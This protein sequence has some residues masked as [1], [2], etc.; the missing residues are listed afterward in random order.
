MQTPH[1]IRNGSPGVTLYAGTSAV[2]TQVV[3]Y[4]VQPGHKI[5]LDKDAVLMIKDRGTTE[6]AN[7]SIVTI[8]AVDP[9]KKRPSIIGD[10][11]YGDLK[12]NQDTRI[13][14]HPVSPGVRYILQ[15]FTYLQ[16]WLTSDQTIASTTFDFWLRAKEE[17]I[18]Y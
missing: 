12:F 3:A 15:P 16:V 13:Q 17:A 7:Q 8:Q 9:A 1:S 4:Q 14:F 10:F 5:V 18:V 6:T 2:A 11:A